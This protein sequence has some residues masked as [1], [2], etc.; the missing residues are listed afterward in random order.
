M[1]TLHIANVKIHIVFIRTISCQPSF[2][3][4]FEQQIP[5][6]VSARPVT[7]CLA[8]FPI[9]YKQLMT[10]TRLF[11]FAFESI[12]KIKRDLLDNLFLLVKERKL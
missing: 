5:C 8:E 9:E 10:W 3:D 12:I 7:V 4:F 6:T 2:F 1:E 11:V